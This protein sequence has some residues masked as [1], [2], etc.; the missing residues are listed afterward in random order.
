MKLTNSI[1]AKAN[2]REVRL[3][4]KEKLV[5]W[6]SWL[7]QSKLN[8]SQLQDELRSS[9]IFML[10]SSFSAPARL[11]V[12]APFYSKDTKPGDGGAE[13]RS[14][15]ANPGGGSYVL[16]LV[17]SKDNETKRQR[18]LNREL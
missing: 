9:I 13:T 3:G 8:I 12:L 4:G 17:Y 18:G 11:T 14:L 7:I 2:E 5:I 10:I 6:H 15:R 1:R 16:P